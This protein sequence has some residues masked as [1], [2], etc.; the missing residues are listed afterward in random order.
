MATSQPGPYHVAAGSAPF[1]SHTANPTPTAVILWD[2]SLG[3]YFCFLFVSEDTISFMFGGIW[4]MCRYMGRLRVILFISIVF[5][6][7]LSLHV[8]GFRPF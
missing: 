5:F 1:S 6:L 7:F 8:I 2:V 4:Y 3:L